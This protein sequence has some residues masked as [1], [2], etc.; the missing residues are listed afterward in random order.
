MSGALDEYPV[1]CPS[2][3]ERHVLYLDGSEPLQ[4]YTEDCSVCCHPMTV[5]VAFEPGESPRVEIEAG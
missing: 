2:C 1:T 3:W 4:T 5:T